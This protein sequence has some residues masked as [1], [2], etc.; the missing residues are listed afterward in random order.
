MARVYESLLNVL[1]CAFY[2][3]LIRQR[4]WN[5]KC[6]VIC[7][8]ELLEDPFREH[9]FNVPTVVVTIWKP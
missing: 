5:L 1:L 6:F 2:L 9:P 4:Y 7:L 3:Y 8:H